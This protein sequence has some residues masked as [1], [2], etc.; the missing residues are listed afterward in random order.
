MPCPDFNPLRCPKCPGTNN[1]VPPD[2]GPYS[3]ASI[4]FV[5]EAPGAN[6]D[7]HGRP[8]IGK[9]GAEFNDHYLRLC[10]LDRDSVYIT[11]TVKCRP[12][13]NQTPKDYLR[14]SCSH[15]HLSEE[16]QR[17]KPEYVVLMGATAC[18]TVDNVNLDI[19]H[20]IP[21]RRT[22]FGHE[23]TVFPMWHP[24]VGMHDTKMMTPLREDFIA[25]NKV[26]RGEWKGPVDEYPRPDYRRLRNKHD[27]KEVFTKLTDWNGDVAIDT[28]TRPGRRPFCLTFSAQPG[29][30]YLVGADNQELV[31]EF[32][33]YM[34][35]WKGR[36]VF[37]NWVYDAGV[38]EL[39]GITLDFKRVQDTMIRSYN[40]GRHLRVGLKILAYRLCGIEMQEFED[41]VLPYAYA[42]ILE[43]L[44]RVQSVE[45][46]KPELVKVIQPDGTWKDKQRQGL[47]Q[48]L[49]RLFTD[50]DKCTDES[51]LKSIIIERWE[52]WDVDIVLPAIEMFGNFPEP[53]IAQ[54]PEHELIGYACRDADATL[55][56]LPVLEK[57]A[58]ELQAK[59]M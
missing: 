35:L 15:W 29:T 52:D 54:V 10:G 32:K 41:L 46:P 42:E 24:A 27:I 12:R 56:L 37:H 18:A 4:M 36:Y 26:L 44:K 48:R 31:D 51:K 25:L 6:E 17:Y 30:G 9:T 47:N 2:M 49:K 57:E 22:L 11:N 5:G 38:L 3:D 16:I 53:D 55:R 34:G 40:L 28:E 7:E 50:L 45:W 14:E 59:V 33:R 43:Y 58:R 19:H 39:M 20:G 13:N 23:C 21:L 1:V 8:F